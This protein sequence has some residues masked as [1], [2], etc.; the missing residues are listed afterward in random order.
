[1][2]SIEKSAIDKFILPL[3]GQDDVGT[4]S[5]F[6]V[7]TKDSSLKKLNLDRLSLEERR[8]HLKAWGRENR[9]VLVIEKGDN[10][11]AHVHNKY[12]Q[13]LKEC[14]ALSF[15]GRKV[16]VKA[17]SDE[18]AA[19]LSAIGE[20]CEDQIAEKEEEK[21]EEKVERQNIY[22]YS[23]AYQLVFGKGG[24]VSNPT[25]FLV[26]Q[27]V[28]H[29]L[30][31]ILIDCMKRFEEARRELEKQK[32]ASDKKSEILREEIKKEILRGGVKKEE[33]SW[34]ELKKIL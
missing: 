28:K 15:G 10:L 13:D 24:E 1:M 21:S 25:R 22:S 31:Q 16:T 2:K 8:E 19:Q 17:L 11:F 18:E 6:M 20:A 32:E 3:E 4:I 26:G 12:A 33:I 7:S 14:E 9:F 30:S 34:I 27:L 5:L 29:H 23:S